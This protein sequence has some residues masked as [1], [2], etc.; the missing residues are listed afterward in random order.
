MCL[1][2]ADKTALLIWTGAA[3]LCKEKL[4]WNQLRTASSA[5]SSRHRPGFNNW[6]IAQMEL[7]SS[8]L[9][10]MSLLEDVKVSLHS[11]EREPVPSGHTHRQG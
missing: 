2:P 4:M 7:G 1:K 5:G 9:H 10:L 11:E 6:A 3:L 8:S